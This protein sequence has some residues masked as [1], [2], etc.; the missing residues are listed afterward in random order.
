M[1]Q[2]FGLVM[3]GSSLTYQMQKDLFDAVGR[4][5]AGFLTVILVTIGA[6]V[7]TIWYLGVHLVGSN[8]ASWP[9]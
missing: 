2:S 4:L 1:A 9:L 8:V 5:H 7:T 6:V 3:V